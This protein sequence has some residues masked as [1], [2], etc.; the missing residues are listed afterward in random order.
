MMRSTHST[1]PGKTIM[2]EYCNH[3][4]SWQTIFERAGSFKV[5]LE[6]FCG[7]QLNGT[8]QYAPVAEY[9]ALQLKKSQSINNGIP[10]QQIELL[11]PGNCPTAAGDRIT[12]PEG[13]FEL[14][15]V[16]YCHDL[17]GKIIIRKCR[18]R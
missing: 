4:D 12:L 13:V 2:N 9:P 11:L 6:R 3:T 7:I 15:E 16:V 18:I 10:D 8:K 17:Q 5:K 1:L 14:D